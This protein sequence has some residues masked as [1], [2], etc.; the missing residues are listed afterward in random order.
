MGGSLRG[1]MTA[2][3]KQFF[4]QVGRT[5]TKVFSL[6]IFRLGL[7]YF[8]EILYSLT[9]LVSHDQLSKV[10]EQWSAETADS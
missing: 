6:C 2:L 3:T 8:H 1:V 7:E 5:K 9:G 10:E 4:L